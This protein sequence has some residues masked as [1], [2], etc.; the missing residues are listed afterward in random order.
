MPATDAPNLD[1]FRLLPRA[2][3]TL[4]HLMLEAESNAAEADYLLD[5]AERALL[6]DDPVLANMA[7]GRA[8][9]LVARGGVSHLN[10]R[11]MEDTD[12]D[13]SRRQEWVRTI[14]R[15]G[16]GNDRRMREIVERHWSMVQRQAAER[17]DYGAR[18]WVHHCLSVRSRLQAVR[19]LQE[20]IHQAEGDP[21]TQNRAYEAL[22]CAA[23]DAR[24]H[25]H[26][27]RATEQDRHLVSSE[28][29]ERLTSET[30][31]SRDAAEGIMAVETTRF[32]DRLPVRLS[33][34]AEGLPDHALERLRGLRITSTLDAHTALY[35]EGSDE[36]REHRDG[37]HSLYVAQYHD[38][39]R[40]IRAATEPLPKDYSDRLAAAQ[41]NN[42]ILALAG[43]D[44]PDPGYALAEAMMAQQLVALGIHKLTAREMDAIVAP[45][46]SEPRDAE[47]AGQI[48]RAICPMPELLCLFERTG[49]M[50]DWRISPAQADAIL[51]RAEAVG[52]SATRLQELARQLGYGP[53][54]G[55][56]KPQPLRA[57]VDP[58][59]IEAATRAGLGQ[60]VTERMFTTLAL[61][62]RR[63]EDEEGPC[64]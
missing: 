41:A 47:Y 48:L 58:E 14:M 50:R 16:Q 54:K 11:E 45:L 32:N 49:E 23:H 39:A 64:P 26:G 43:E 6:G 18:F 24:A 21:Q 42:R 3:Y 38:D 12:R 52:L 36:F 28:R 31:A 1:L 2:N 17:P 56:A 44:G 8:D 53:A 62:P 4:R 15:A 33:P 51:N 25:W 7:L 46:R 20:R 57:G 13:E 59:L 35:E 55:T 34:L 37:L 60:S 22:E 9:S 63:T 5:T 10:L 61:T 30:E 29:A 19:T 27:A 40:L